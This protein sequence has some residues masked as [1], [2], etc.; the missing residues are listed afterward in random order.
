MRNNF[1]DPLVIG[2]LIQTSM[3]ASWFGPKTPP[4]RGILKTFGSGA[5]AKEPTLKIYNLLMKTLLKNCATCSLVAA[6]QDLS[7]GTEEVCCLQAG[8]H[9]ARLVGR[10]WQGGSSKVAAPRFEVELQCVLSL[11]TS[12]C[13]LNLPI[14][15]EKLCESVSVS[16]INRQIWISLARTS[17]DSL[18]L[19]S[20]SH[21]FINHFTAPEHYN[22]T[23]NSGIWDL[24]EI[25]SRQS[26]AKF[27]SCPLNRDPLT[28][29]G[30]LP[31]AIN[32]SD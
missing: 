20:K 29:S 22:F 26:A 10:D 12:I 13:F 6:D 7:K 27:S 25:V 14:L 16:F 3:L 17:H 24:T 19:L 8:P 15:P 30:I 4:G 18:S 2:A 11:R 1:K 5:I 32:K 31:I 21:I 28:L 23:C 9:I